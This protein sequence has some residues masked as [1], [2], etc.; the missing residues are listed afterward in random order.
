MN[1]R[2]MER[3]AAPWALRRGESESPVGDDIRCTRLRS[4]EIDPAVTQRQPAAPLR[5]SLGNVNHC[6]NAQV[7]SGFVTVRCARDRDGRSGR[8][9]QL[10]AC[11]SR[12]KSRVT[13]R[14]LESMLRGYRVSRTAIERPRAECARAPRVS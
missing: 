8:D 13:L 14:L 7:E 3:T 12:E 1:F 9:C 4:L 11:G 6:L 5:V 10:T 2:R